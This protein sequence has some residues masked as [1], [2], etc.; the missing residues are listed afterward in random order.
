MLDI[1]VQE[2]IR[3]SYCYEV[4]TPF[5]CAYREINGIPELSWER[6]RTQCQ[7]GGHF[8]VVAAA[9]FLLTVLHA[10]AQIW[11]DSPPS[12]AP[13]L[14]PA[15]WI[16]L[17]I[18]FDDHCLERGICPQFKPKAEKESQPV[19]EPLEKSSRMGDGKTYTLKLWW[20][21]GY[22]GRMKLTLWEAEQRRKEMKSFMISHEMLYWTLPEGKYFYDF[23]SYISSYIFFII[24]AGFSYHL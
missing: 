3:N 13:G 8:L 24:W 23:L 9:S 4:L 10:C 22:Y 11:A 21:F 17:C 12:L 7:Y 5:W 15:S 1:G 16:N 6:C 2:W 19:S 20:L 18:S 14:D